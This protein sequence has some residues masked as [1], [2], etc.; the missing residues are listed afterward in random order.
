MNSRLDRVQ[1]TSG[2]ARGRYRGEHHG[3]RGC[4]ADRHELRTGGRGIGVVTWPGAD[5]RI[6]PSIDGR[7]HLTGGVNHSASVVGERRR[8][9]IEAGTAIDRGRVRIVCLSVV[10]HVRGHSERQSWQVQDIRGPLGIHRDL[11]DVVQADR[12][13]ARLND[14]SLVCASRLNV[15]I[16]I[17]SVI[18]HMGKTASTAVQLDR[19]IPGDRDLARKQR[20]R[21]DPQIVSS[22]STEVLEAVHAGEGK[23]GAVQG[24]R[25]RLLTVGLQSH[26]IRVAGPGECEIASPVEGR[27]RTETAEVHLFRCT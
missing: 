7:G 12:R 22:A 25:S 24:G 23:L 5:D 10:G 15:D 6:L 14:Q 9:S 20:Q 13:N 18:G 16:W 27:D 2:R 8:D 17:L 4:R 19:K 1:R 26:G 21:S 3:A 11:R